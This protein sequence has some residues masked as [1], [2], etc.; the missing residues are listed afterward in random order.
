[1]ANLPPISFANQKGIKHKIFD[2]VEDYFYLGGKK[3]V[4]IKKNELNGN[5]ICEIKGDSKDKLKINM[6]TALKISSYLT[7]VIPFIMYVT[8]FAIRKT[9]KFQIMKSPKMFQKKS[10]VDREKEI[11]VFGDIH[12]ELDGFKENL[13]HAKVLDE[14]GNFNKDF[15]DIVLQMG[16]VVDRGP[17]SIEA[18]KFLQNLQENA[19][20][21][22]VIRLLGNH[23]LMLLQKK[24]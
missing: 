6:L 9:L 21:G 23:E 13:T 16:D 1:M 8:R 10:R 22:Q 2:F 7:A 20:I 24:L 17:K 11:L 18:W 5:Y 3:A 14:K 19:N 12:G 15:K 4:V